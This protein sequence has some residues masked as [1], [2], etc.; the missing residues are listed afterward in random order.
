[1]EYFQ[2]LIQAET[3]IQQAALAGNVSRARAASQR[4]KQLQAKAK[5]ESQQLV[6]NMPEAP[7]GP[8]SPQR[9][10]ERRLTEDLRRIESD[11]ARLTVTRQNHLAKLASSPDDESLLAVAEDCEHRLT[12]A[13]RQ[14][15]AIEAR[16]GQIAA[17]HQQQ[18]RIA[19]EQAEAKAAKGRTKERERL[20]K[21]A[22]ATGGLIAELWQELLLTLRKLDE[23][24][25]RLKELS[26][27]K[28]SCP[29]VD[30]A[31][32]RIQ[33]ATSGAVKFI[34]GDG[35]RI[36]RETAI[37]YSTGGRTYLPAVSQSRYNVI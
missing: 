25:I 35:P 1:M 23:T 9:G 7:R 6:A 5:L 8:E 29:P 14:Q 3:E 2:E 28:N 31:R 15:Q 19:Q 24:E 36:P 21:A 4:R 16:Q 22:T 13:R 26:G 17:F 18:Q 30:K 20:E 11:I 37:S 10:E 27:L 12:T 34:E 32:A 33:Q